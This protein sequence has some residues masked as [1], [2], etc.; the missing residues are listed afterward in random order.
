MH[1]YTQPAPFYGGIG[2]GGPHI[3]M[4]SGAYTT[5]FGAGLSDYFIRKHF[6]GDQPIL[7]NVVYLLVAVPVASFASVIQHEYFGHGYRCREVGGSS[8]ITLF[9]PFPYSLL[10]NKVSPVAGFAT[11]S[12]NTSG[13]L[14]NDLL[15][16]SGGNEANLI[17]ARIEK[18]RWYTQFKHKQFST[19]H[20]FMSR[21]GVLT[22]I[23]FDSDSGS[24]GDGYQGDPYSYR[25]KLALKY[26]RTEAIS[27]LSQRLQSLWLLLDPAIYGIGPWEV[28]NKTDFTFTS[29]FYLGPYG[30][31]FQVD[32][33]FITAEKIITFTPRFSP[34]I[35]KTNGGV[36]FRGRR[37]IAVSDRLFFGA[38]VDGWYQPKSN[39]GLA[40]TSMQ[41]G[42][43]A[44]LQLQCVI[45]STLDLEGWG[46]YKT[47]GYLPGRSFDKETFFFAALNM[48]LPLDLSPE[49]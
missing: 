23:L 2:F 20:Y 19:L 45:N 47:P 27:A 4:Y 37:I 39:N 43:S 40:E 12:G 7:N 48:K 38:D 30:P 28:A 21:L 6:Y 10:Q 1:S 24:L 22:Y 25:E 26:D 46:G 34:G 49:L 16:V 41:F 35:E 44:A 5:Q 18:E 36:G 9:P 42:G 32:L 17:A 3:D 15:S 29:E 31:E 8:S 14:D 33:I 11:C 13:T